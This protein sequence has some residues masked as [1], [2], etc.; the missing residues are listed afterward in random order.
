MPRKYGYTKKFRK[1]GIILKLTLHFTKKRLAKLDKLCLKD[2]C[3]RDS[4][5]TVIE[6]IVNERLDGVRL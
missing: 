4:Y 2:V 1:E 3:S 6:D 5:A